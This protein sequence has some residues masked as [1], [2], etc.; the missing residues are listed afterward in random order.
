VNTLAFARCNARPSTDAEAVDVFSHRTVRRSA[1]GG[2]HFVPPLA[3]ATVVVGVAGLLAE[4]H[5][6][7]TPSNS[8]NLESLMDLER[9]MRGPTAIDAVVKRPAKTM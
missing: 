7:K 9:L 8:P 4:T 5:P 3:R 2:P 6:D 1:G